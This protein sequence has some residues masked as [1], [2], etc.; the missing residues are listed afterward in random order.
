MD[1]PK[2]LPDLG[3]PV[4][5]RLLNVDEL[6]SASQGEILHAATVLM[7]TLSQRMA[8]PHAYNE[9]A[10]FHDAAGMDWSGF[11]SPSEPASPLAAEGLGST[12]LEKT[13]QAERN[14]DEA[15]P[16]PLEPENYCDSLPAMGDMLNQLSRFHAS[17]LTQYSRYLEASMADQRQYLGTPRK[18]KD[19]RDVADYLTTTMHISRKDARKIIRRGKYLAHRPGLH[20]EA[21]DAKPVFGQLAQSMANGNLPI[22]NADK[23]IDFDEELIKYSQKTHQPLERKNKVLQV[24]EP[25]MVETAESTTPDEL[26]KVKKRWVEELA[27]WI[28]PDGPSPSRAFA[29]AADNALKCRD[30]ADGSA[31]FSMHATPAVSANF[32]NWMLQQLD[33]AGSPV[34]ISDEALKVLGFLAP[35]ADDATGDDPAETAESRPVPQEPSPPEPSQDSEGTEDEGEPLTIPSAWLGPMTTWDTSPDPTRVVAETS[36]GTPLTGRDMNLI[37]ELTTGQKMGGILLSH[38]LTLLSMDPTKLGGKKAHGISAQLIVVQD[39]ETAYHTLG[40]GSIPKAA[41]RPSG[42][43]GYRPPVIKRPNPDP[44]DEPECTDK[45][46][47]Y[48]RLVPPDPAM[49]DDEPVPWTPYH[50]ETVNIGPIHPDDVELLMCNATISGQIWNGPDQVLQEKR[51]QRLFTA[52]QRRAILARDK[53]C[54]APGCPVP[55]AYC[56]IHHIKAWGNGG[57]TDEDNGIALCPFHHD[58][59]H[60]GRW[61]I[62]KHKGLTFF[63]PARWID[64]AQPLLRNAY[65]NS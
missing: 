31:I 23:L 46:H 43:E 3:S 36:E 15:V 22:E 24:F 51:A 32:K 14:L 47:H 27:H 17:A 44:P 40:L 29:K 49:G 48:S 20:A 54:Q 39:I 5:T 11:Q 18:T 42:P 34:L 21:P 4:S 65:W 45:P 63:Q 64:P 30:Q 12:T 33:F 28:C 19:F 8:D 60:Q 9:V 26:G 58:A 55:G 50:S 53:G 2:I 37:D 10:T 13:E 62:R 35:D 57:L 38:M 6:E 25:V 59:M 52:A 7:R 1:I 16:A 56:D 41:R 61:I